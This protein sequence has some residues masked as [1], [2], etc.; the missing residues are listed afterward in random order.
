M[1]I[2][3]FDCFSGISGDMTLAALLHLGVPEEALR[4]ELG[5][6]GLDNY[7]LEIRKGSRSGIAAMSLEVKV[8]PREEHHRHFSHIRDLILGSSLEQE[9]KDLSLAIFRKLAEA[10][11]RVHGQTVDDVHFH[12]VGAVDSIVDI[13]GTAIGI[14]FLKPEKIYSSELPMGRGFIQSQHGRLPL[15]APATVEILKGYPVRSADIEG[16]LVTPTGAAIVAALSS[17]AVPFPSMKPI[18]I[19]YGMG[20]KE[21]PDRPNL[22]RAVIGESSAEREADDAVVLEANIDDMNPEFYDAVMDR[23]FHAG[24]LDVSLS[25]VMMKKNRPGTLLRVI[26][27]ERDAESLGEVILRETTTLGVRQYSVRRRKLPREVREVETRFGKVRVKVSGAVRF[28]PEYDDC[29][30]IAAEKGV[31]VQE[32]YAEAMRQRG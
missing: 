4:S 28:Q 14:V 23:L 29:K 6:L 26:A 3:Y 2:L 17:G 19:G 1:K 11:A 13:V 30:R 31:P 5:K 16:E 15:P 20:K 8:G 7:T 21:F 22:L 24:A 27:E 9:T 18:D 12:E 10:E 25:P 32:V